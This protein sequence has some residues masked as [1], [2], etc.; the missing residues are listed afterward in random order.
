MPK[1]S[2]SLNFGIYYITFSLLWRWTMVWNGME[3]NKIIIKQTN[4]TTN[5]QTKAMARN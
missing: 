4:K 5:K 3:D 2:N 1:F